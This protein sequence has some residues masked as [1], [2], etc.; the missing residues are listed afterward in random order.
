MIF[1]KLLEGLYR[2]DDS[3]LLRYIIYTMSGVVFL[4]NVFLAV[5]FT[6]SLIKQG[7]ELTNLLLTLTH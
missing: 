7:V 2:N 3:C 4:I 5:G 6:N 1:F